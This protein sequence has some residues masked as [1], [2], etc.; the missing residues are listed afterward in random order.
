VLYQ[1]SQSPRTPRSHELIVYSQASARARGSISAQSMSLQ[2]HRTGS[3]TT[4]NR[5]RSDSNK[6]QSFSQDIESLGDLINHTIEPRA[7]TAQLP[8][9]MVSE[10]SHVLSWEN[11]RTDMWICRP[12]RLMTIRCAGWALRKTALSHLVK[13]VSQTHVRRFARECSRPHYLLCDNFEFR[14]SG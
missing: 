8:P 3:T 10:S 13:K 7:R 6:T 5:L 1:S 2:R 9:V 14:S 4:A 11:L 12:K